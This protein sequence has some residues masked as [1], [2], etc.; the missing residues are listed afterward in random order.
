ML[1]STSI[2]L[3][4]DL[5]IKLL[6]QLQDQKKDMQTLKAEHAGANAEQIEQS[7]VSPLDRRFGQPTKISI[8]LL[9][10]L[11]SSRM[12]EETLARK[13]KQECV[14]VYH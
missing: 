3:R 14:Q 6:K 7:L 13:I 4:K 12:R 2:R 11:C 10:L 9:M 5:V 1:V 8:Y